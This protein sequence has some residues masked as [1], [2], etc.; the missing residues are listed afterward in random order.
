MKGYE[1]YIGRPWERYTPTIISAGLS[2][3]RCKKRKVFRAFG[4]EGTVVATKQLCER[5]KPTPI[6][7]WQAQSLP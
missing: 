6:R 1:D 5:K 7:R 2:G 4:I 3:E